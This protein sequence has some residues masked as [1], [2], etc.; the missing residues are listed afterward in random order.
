MATKVL[1]LPFLQI[2]MGHHQTAD[3]L[4][5]HLTAIDPSIECEIID[6]LDYS[7]GR[8]VEGLVSSTYLK[9]IHFLPVTYSWMYRKN[10]GGQLHNKR[11]YRLYEM[12]FLKAMQKLIREKKPDCILCTHALPSYLLERLKYNG[13]LAIPVINVYTDFFVND[14]W[15]RDGI[16]YHF[17]PDA[18]VKAWLTSRSVQA[19]HIFVTGIPLHP[20]FTASRPERTKANSECTV[21]ITGGNL[22]AGVMKSMCRTIGKA[23]GVRYIVLCG[24]NKALYR[25]LKKKNCPNIVPMPYIESRAEMNDL[26]NQADAILTKPGGVTISECLYKKVPIFVYHALPGQE[27]INLLRLLQQQLIIYV[28]DW[29]QAQVTMDKQIKL[30]WNNTVMERLTA[31][32]NEYGRQISDLRS[33][34]RHVLKLP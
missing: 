13:L 24:K 26:Y 16:D 8:R 17:V 18:H 15:G 6:I 11:R 28:K 2:K 4:V 19:E 7:Y 12:I 27:E 23:E 20:Q 14:V 31:Q 25:H 21:L 32:M 29:A 33:T 3:A 34:L 5:E 9:W 22:G 1:L 10:C 30:L